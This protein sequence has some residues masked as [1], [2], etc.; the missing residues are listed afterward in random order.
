MDSLL[1]TTPPQ[2]DENATEVILQPKEL[3]K[4]LDGLCL[5]EIPESVDKL[6]K[7]VTAFNA[8]TMTKSERIKLLEIYHEAYE[9]ILVN[10][11]DMRIKQLK[12]RKPQRE[13]LA[14]QIVWLYLKLAH[15]YNVIVHDG[16]AQ[17]I[18]P[19]R[20]QTLLLAIFRSMELLSDALIYAYRSK[21]K[22][23]ALAYLE[24]HQLF[25]FA[26]HH[27]V[28]EQRIKAARGYAKTP[29]ISGI[30]KLAMIMGVLDTAQFDSIDIEAMV[31]A[32]QPFAQYCT[33]SADTQNQLMQYRY[34]I[35]L[36]EDFAPRAGDPTSKRGESSWRYLSVDPMVDQLQ[37]WLDKNQNNEDKLFIDQELTLFP[38][39]LEIIGN[40]AKDVGRQPAIIETGQTVSVLIGFLPLQSL[41]ITQ[42][43]RLQ[44]ALKYNLSTWAVHKKTDKGCELTAELDAVPENIVLGE[45]VAL[46]EKDADTG[47]VSL[48]MVAYITRSEL[49]HDGKILLGVEYLSDQAKPLTFTPAHRTFEA[50]NAVPLS[51]IY[52]PKNPHR[53]EHAHLIIDKAHFED[54]GEYRVKTG[55]QEYHVKVEELVQKTTRQ[56]IFRFDVL[57]DSDPQP[58][59]V[60]EN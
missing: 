23:P 28:L 36:N 47:V 30:Y 43:A 12:L 41:L 57:A 56:A 37:E 13:K 6:D 15:G 45:V 55:G 51:G 38:R 5:S 3:I 18:S 33:L 25:A 48:R 22:K 34:T 4:W 27:G 32:L 2:G 21:L 35:K 54:N 40:Q 44:L 19:K 60:H 59:V 58:K 29:S 24:L 20:S 42:A 1:L 7:S 50:H 31:F 10:F 9:R 52:L 11:D 39:V 49:A 14:N 17:N 16:Y 53:T 26:E 8:A 46:V